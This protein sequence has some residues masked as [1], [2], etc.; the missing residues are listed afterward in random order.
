MSEHK[1][2]AWYVTGFL[3][4]ALFT[5][6]IYA[7]HDSAVASARAARANKTDS[8]AGCPFSTKSSASPPPSEDPA[9]QSCCQPKSPVESAAAANKAPAKVDF[10][11]LADLPEEEL[12]E[13][14]KRFTPEQ[15]AKC[16]HL[17]PRKTKNKRQ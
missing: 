16:P 15:L 8:A 13:F 3:L 5:W 4:F 6:A 14:K 10:K 9:K 7:V 11:S 1:K 2:K 17:N 12:E